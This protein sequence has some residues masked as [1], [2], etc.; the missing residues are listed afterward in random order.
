MEGAHKSQS[1]FQ[2]QAVECILANVKTTL[3]NDTG[4]WDSR[5]IDTFVD[6]TQ[7]VAK[8][9]PCVTGNG[10]FILDWEFVYE[11]KRTVTEPYKIPDPS[12][13]KVDDIP[14]LKHSVCACS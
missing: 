3:V 5:S 9:G 1:S 10:N 8:A 6:I 13:C 14:K 2:F 12:I 4:M 7:A 11:K